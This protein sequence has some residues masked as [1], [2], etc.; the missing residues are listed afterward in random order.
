MVHFQLSPCF[1]ELYGSRLNGELC[2]KTE[3]IDYI[4]K[5]EALEKRETIMIGDRKHDMIGAK[6]N[7]I[8]AIG[9][10]YG[11]GSIK[12]LTSAQADH[13]IDT[14]GALLDIVMNPPHPRQE[15]T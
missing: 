7:G 3:L 12:E 11:Y 4:L 8:K 14:P 13:I 6:N 5:K 10:S 2:D 1:T 9:V 15:E